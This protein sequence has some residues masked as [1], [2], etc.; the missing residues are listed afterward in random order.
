MS[1]VLRTEEA[2]LGLLQYETIMET[3][4][5][6]FMSRFVGFVKVDKTTG[7]EIP[8]E[9]PIIMKTDFKTQG[10]D[11]ILIPM[12]KNLTQQAKYG[13]AQVSGQGEAQDIWYNKAYINQR[14]GV[15]EPPSRNSNQRIKRLNLYE[16]SRPQ[17]TDWLAR[18]TEI[19]MMRAFYEG[20]SE[21]ITTATA[22]G[23]LGITKRYHPAIFTPDSGQITWNAT[24]ATYANSIHTAVNGWAGADDQ[25]MS[26]NALWKFRTFCVKREIPQMNFGGI[27]FWPL[28][29]HPNQVRQLSLDPTFMNGFHQAAERDM[30]KNSV[31]NGM[32]HFYAGFAIFE[33]EFSVFGASTTSTAITWGATNPK[34]AVDSY[35]VKAAVVF[36]NSALC[37]GWAFGPHFEEEVTN[38][39]IKREVSV[40]MI[41]GY[42]RGESSDSTSSP[43]QAPIQKSSALLLTYSP[44]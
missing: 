25:I 43:T 2:N 6:L 13:D 36:G 24:L 1:L 18:D 23:G 10:M 32:F 15:V 29:L 9:K 17:L 26:A 14:I 34:S 41:D 20:Y 4:K 8:P 42:A 28:L 33:R 5:K 3:Y 27:S 19:Q 7:E 35:N 16:A 39:A 44:D 37:G 30:R 38:H 11:S 22:S 21:N 12:L 40:A 31:F